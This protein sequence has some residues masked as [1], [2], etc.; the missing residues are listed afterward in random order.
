[1]AWCKSRSLYALT[2][3]FVLTFQHCLAAATVRVRL[4]V[5][6]EEPAVIQLWRKRLSTRLQEGSAIIAQYCSVRFVVADFGTWDSDNR[7]TDFTKT[8][9]EFEQEVSTDRFHLAIGFTSQYRF[10]AGRNN[11]GGI[12]GPLSGHILLRESAP[13]IREPERLEALVHELGHFLGAAHCANP[14]SVMRPVVA[15]GRARAKAFRIQF[16]PDNAEV[17]RAVAREVA[18]LRVRQFHYLTDATK[19]R[20]REHYVQLAKD[21]PN[22]PTARRY[23]QSIDQ[24]IGLRQ[25]AGR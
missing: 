14:D 9:R 2:A 18:D 4:L 6:E 15:D 3:V 24:T 10:R 20:I 25:R 13:T 17:I 12:R 16:D 22:D 8:L 7:L 11:L 1:M 19:R 5:D 21:F 23:I